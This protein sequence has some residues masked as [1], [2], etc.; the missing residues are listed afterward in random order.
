MT[1]P[2]SPWGHWQC[3]EI[4]LVAALERG[5]WLLASWWRSG[6]LLSTLQCTGEPPKA[7]DD[8]APNSEKPCTSCWRAS[9]SWEHSPHDPSLIHSVS[10]WR[11]LFLSHW[12]WPTRPVISEYQDWVGLLWLPSWGHTA[13]ADPKLRE[14]CKGLQGR[15]AEKPWK[16]VMFGGMQPPFTQ[17]S[18]FP[19][20]VCSQTV[21]AC[22]I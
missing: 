5:Y 16:L 7:T 14:R 9:G 15:E 6:M 12:P 1:L 20:L 21:M 17:V 4:I 8:L 2:P 11:L 18:G 19:I 22:L 3:L 13:G 10:S